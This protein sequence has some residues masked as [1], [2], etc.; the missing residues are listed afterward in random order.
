FNGTS[1]LEKL[2][3]KRVVF[4]GDSLGKNHW[5]SLLCLIDSWITEPSNKVVEW[6]GSLITFKATEYNV[7]IDFYWEPLLVESNCDNPI[8]HRVLDR[9][10][11]IDSI[12]KHAK[13]W[14][15]A[16]MLVFDSYAWWLEPNMTLL[17][18]SFE[19]PTRTFVESG[20]VRRYE[21]AMKTWS[22]WLENHLDHT[23]TRIFFT[24]LSPEHKKGQDWGKPVGTN[25][26]NETEPITKK[27]Y[28]G[29]DTSTGLMRTVE[30]VVQD[31]RKKNFKIEILNITQ[32]SQYRKDGHPTI[33]KRHWVPPT[34][35][36]LANP[37][38]TADCS[39]WCLPGVPDVWNE[40]F[41]SCIRYR[42]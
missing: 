4:V 37:V 1:L 36:E 20:I 7:S 17:W 14:I 25:C 23:K 10:M 33:F 12:A 28:W 24:S 34:A 38:K 42:L 5:V 30:S 22:N 31:L 11:K 29:N 41:Y 13:N 40:I 6:H 21:M 19:N 18:G 35:L 26:F 2:R 8:K 27:G 39:H 3:D 32:L 9:V 15:D 16:D